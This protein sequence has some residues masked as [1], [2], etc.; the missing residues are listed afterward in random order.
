MLLEHKFLPLYVWSCITGVKSSLTL[1]QKLLQRIPA[2][3]PALIQRIEAR[4]Q[5]TQQLYKRYIWT[6]H[7]VYHCSD[8]NEPLSLSSY[9]RQSTPLIVSSPWV[10]APC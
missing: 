5:T 8:N 3:V 4:D 1:T 2:K 7:V 9:T 10:S 6:I